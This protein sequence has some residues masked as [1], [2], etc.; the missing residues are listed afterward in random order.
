MTTEFSAAETKSAQGDVAAAFD[1]FVR[2]F[3]A[4]RETTIRVSMRSKRASRPMS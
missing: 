1:E 3:E 2:G 4:F